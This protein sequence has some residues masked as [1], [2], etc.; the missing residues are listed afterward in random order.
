[1]YK[2]LSSIEETCSQILREMGID[3]S[4]LKGIINTLDI[5]K[6]DI[7]YSFIQQVLFKQLLHLRYYTRHW[8]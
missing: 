7:N 2:F 8:R 4:I 1:M 6:L 3:V 5:F